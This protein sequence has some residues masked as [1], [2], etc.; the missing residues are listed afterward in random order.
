MKRL[1]FL[2]VVFFISLNAFSEPILY[3]IKARATYHVDSNTPKFD[4]YNAFAQ[5]LDDGRVI[6]TDIT[7]TWSYQI[8]KACGSYNSMSFDGSTYQVWTF[9]IEDPYGRVG[10][11]DVV[12]FDRSL[13]H[14][15]IRNG[16]YITDYLLEDIKFNVQ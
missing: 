4:E 8:T 2:L 3:L 9:M 12:I 16:D 7:G 6:F 1:S 11:L 15:A 5:Q 14:L 13:T 10:T